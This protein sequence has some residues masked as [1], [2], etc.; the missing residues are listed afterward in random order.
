MGM[1]GDL[2]RVGGGIIETDEN[3][4]ALRE[5][6]ERPDGY[7]PLARELIDAERVSMQVQRNAA[8]T[9]GILQQQ[10]R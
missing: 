7:L 1:S 10:P 3:A 6:S 8:C 5:R 2:T 4:R 9:Q